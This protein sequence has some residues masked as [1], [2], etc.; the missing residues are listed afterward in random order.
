VLLDLDGVLYAG[1]RALPGAADFL[2]TVAREKCASCIASN[3]S[4]HAP[5]DLSRALAAVGVAV[6]PE[7]I[8]TAGLATGLFLKSE[9]REG[10][11][12]AHVVG[13]DQLRAMIEASGVATE[14]AAPTDVVVG[15]DI[16]F[17]FDSLARAI[18]YVRDGARLIGVDDDARIPSGTGHIPGAGTLVAAISKGAQ[19]PSFTIGKPSPYVVT[20]ALE[21]LGIRP[22]H[23]LLI[24]DNLDTDI[25][26]GAAAG[27]HTALVLTGVSGRA[28]VAAAPV[29][30]DLVAVDLA[31]L[32]ERLGWV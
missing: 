1:D 8:V 4:R 11:P 10:P 14:G 16:H 13:S 2:T 27:V 9:R 31:E 32:A 21:R 18:A 30:P 29:Q 23:A 20:L 25:V 28:E 6:P 22:E 3:D 26:A 15:V 17:T 24:G 12:V 7:H 5:T 19:A